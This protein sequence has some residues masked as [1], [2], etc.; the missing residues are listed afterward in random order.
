[1]NL[2]RFEKKFFCYAFEVLSRN[3]FF[4]ILAN[5]HLFVL[6]DGLRQAPI[7]LGSSTAHNRFAFIP[8]NRLRMITTNRFGDG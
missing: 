4:V 8:P 1:L 2:L 6:V 7:D 3:G 5:L